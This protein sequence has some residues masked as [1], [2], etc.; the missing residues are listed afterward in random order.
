MKRNSQ[1][2]KQKG[3]TMNYTNKLYY[4]T[5]LINS[6]AKRIRHARGKKALNLLH[7]IQDCMIEE[8]IETVAAMNDGK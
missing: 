7:S 2:I 6:T 5:N 4:Y 8:F 3:I 1:F